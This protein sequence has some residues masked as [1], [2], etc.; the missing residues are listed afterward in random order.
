MTKTIDR[1]R[2]L[3]FADKRLH[4]AREIA[5]R[6]DVTGTLPAGQYAAYRDALTEAA[7]A[8][9]LAGLGLLAGRVATMAR[10]VA[11]PGAALNVRVEWQ[12]FD[13]L[14]ASGKGAT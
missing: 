12:R 9:T 14:N 2:A 4:E 7:A 13:R 1:R 3:A 5:D 11:R 8:F 10:R 6:T